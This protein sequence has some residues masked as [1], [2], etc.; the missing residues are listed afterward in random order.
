MRKKKTQNSTTDKISYRLISEGEGEGEG[1]RE[2]EREKE[3]KLKD[4]E[5]VHIGPRSFGGGRKKELLNGEVVLAEI[6]CL[7]CHYNLFSSYATSQRQ[8]LLLST[9]LCGRECSR[10]SP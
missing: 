6:F 8:Q 9:H 4:V 1:E 5:V 7:T 3:I 2:R 10:F